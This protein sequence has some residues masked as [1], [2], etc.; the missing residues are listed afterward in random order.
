MAGGI[1]EYVTVLRLGTAEAEALLRR[2]T[3]TSVQHPT[4]AAMAGLGKV[5]KTLFLCEYLRLRASG[6]RSARG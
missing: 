5:Y 2:F 3:R 4:Y 1:V 6:A